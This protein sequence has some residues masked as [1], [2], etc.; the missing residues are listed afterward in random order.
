MFRRLAISAASLGL[1]CG[2]LGAPEPTSAEVADACLLLEENRD[3]HRAMRKSAKEWGAPM[4]FQLA[5]IKQESNFDHKAKPARGKRKMLGLLPGD[6]PSSAYGYAQA[7]DT[8]W[9][10]YKR[11]SGN[12]GADRHDFDD[13]VDFIGWYFAKTGQMTGAGQYDYRAH[14]L[15]YHEGQS[16]YL[17]GSWR[18]KRWLVDVANRVSS[19]ATRYEKQIASCKALRSKFLGI[20]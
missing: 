20:F 13:S 19:T 2:C 8:T 5:V 14:Y 7:L 10:T 12:G 6:R 16:G 9:E 11:E 3:W 1:L 18:S 4:G 17:K 15:A